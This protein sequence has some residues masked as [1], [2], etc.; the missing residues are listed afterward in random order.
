[1]FKNSFE[2]PRFFN[3]SNREYYVKVFVYNILSPYITDAKLHIIFV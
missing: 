3:L 1:M 2:R